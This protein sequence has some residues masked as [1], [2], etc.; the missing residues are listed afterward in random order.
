MITATL[1]LTSL[2]G[3]AYAIQLDCLQRD[4]FTLFAKNSFDVTSMEIATT[5]NFSGLERLAILLTDSDESGE[6]RSS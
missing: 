2:V 1:L 6:V 5:E 3:T 4:W